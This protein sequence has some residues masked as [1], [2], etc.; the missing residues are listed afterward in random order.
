MLEKYEGI[1]S[2]K[3]DMIKR[4]KVKIQF[5][6]TNFYIINPKW[7]DSYDFTL[8]LRKDFVQTEKKSLS[9]KANVA[10]NVAAL[11]RAKSKRSQGLRDKLRLL[12]CTQYLVPANVCFHLMKGWSFR[13]VIPVMRI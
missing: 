4:S 12:L 3:W 7:I 13:T 11:P 5:T 2:K 9:K 1:I 8:V 10:A 6:V